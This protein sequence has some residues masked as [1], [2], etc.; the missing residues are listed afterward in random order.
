[1]R[2]SYNR[3]D[4]VLMIETARGKIDHAVESWPIILHL[5]KEGKP[6]LVEILRASEFLT[7]ATRIGLKSRKETLT[8]LPLRL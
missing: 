5:N 3:E 7:Q 8:P 2:L 6:V 4:D 1:M